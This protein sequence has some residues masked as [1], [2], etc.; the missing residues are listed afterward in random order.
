MNLLDQVLD[1]RAERL[2]GQLEA[3]YAQFTHNLPASLSQL[4]QAESTYLGE[5]TEAPFSGLRAMNPLITQATWLFWE[6]F[7]NLEDEIL[8]Q[9]ADAGVCMA[10]AS[11]LIDHLADGQVPNPGSLML[12]RQS[13]EDRALS[14]YHRS[15]P[16]DSQFWL[17][18]ERL[19]GDY[20]AALQMEIDAQSNPEL[21]EFEYFRKFA[22][23]KVSPMVITVAA[24][25]EASGQNDLLHPIESSM[26]CSYI[27]GQIH[28]DILD[29]QVDLENK[30]LTLFLI[31]LANEYEFGSESWPGLEDLIQINNTDWLDVKQL[32]LA[33]EWFDQAIDAVEGIVCPGWVDYLSEYRKIAEGDQQTALAKHLFR[34]LES[35]L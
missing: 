25:T 27:A 8:L 29:W 17:E 13:L 24:L 2:L 18:Y 31:N 20:I 30:H 21:L 5:F 6:T 35:K 34:K 4:A 33:I 15:Y 32:Y 10:L 12:L 28:D 19:S 11:V 3:R 16:S 1:P 22:A 9:L 14:L 23:G 26:R 7:K